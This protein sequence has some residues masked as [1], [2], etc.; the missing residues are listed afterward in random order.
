MVFDALEKFEKSIKG[1]EPRKATPK[2]QKKKLYEKQKGKCNYCGR[3]RDID[4]LVVDHKTPLSRRGTD[5]PANKQILCSSCNGRKSDCTDGEFRK[6]YKLTPARKA[7][8]PPAQ[9]ISQGYFNNIKK[10]LDKKRAKKIK[11]EEEGFLI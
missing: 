3:K 7:K 6:R 9:E 11:A 8:N 2:Q 5:T 10:E 1:I 4:E